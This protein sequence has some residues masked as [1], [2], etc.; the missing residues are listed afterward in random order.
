MGALGVLEQDETKYYLL[1]PAACK[2]AKNSDFTNF[3][4][5]TFFDIFLAIH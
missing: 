4:S 2:T 1:Y 3:N 5:L